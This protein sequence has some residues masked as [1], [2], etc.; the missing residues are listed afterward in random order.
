MLRMCDILIFILGLFH[1]CLF[2]SSYL[3]NS[4]PHFDYC[5]F[6]MWFNIWHGKSLFF[7]NPFITFKKCYWYFLGIVL[8]PLSKH[9]LSTYKDRQTIVPTFMKFTVYQESSI[10]PV[11]LCITKKGRQRVPRKLRANNMWTP[12]GRAMSVTFTPLCAAAWSVLGAQWMLVHKWKTKT[13]LGLRG[14]KGVKSLC[15]LLFHMTGEQG[16]KSEGVVQ[17]KA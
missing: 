12:W 5:S 4:V 7:W 1:E 10:K 13:N 6:K 11:F 9:V 2:C 16:R 3:S 17:N 8:N 15:C 14:N